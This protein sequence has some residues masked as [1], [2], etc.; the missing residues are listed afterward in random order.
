[1]FLKVIYFL[2]DEE[3][4][5]GVVEGTEVNEDLATSDHYQMWEEF[6]SVAINL[7]EKMETFLDSLDSHESLEVIN[8][9]QNLGH[10]T[11]NH[12]SSEYEVI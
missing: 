3:R 5:F 2:T 9:Q 12:A 11:F 7:L 4:L 1:M 6:A 10:L 8:Q